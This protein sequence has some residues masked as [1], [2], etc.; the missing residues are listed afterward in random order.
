MC[1]FLQTKYKS[2]SFTCVFF[3]KPNINLFP[4]HVFRR[5]VLTLQTK[6]KST[7]WHMFDVFV[8]LSKIDVD[9]SDFDCLVNNIYNS[10]EIYPTCE[11]SW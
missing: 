4:F 1:I 8:C 9:Q 7:S 2:I 6:Y 11:N 5:D 10:C 3:T